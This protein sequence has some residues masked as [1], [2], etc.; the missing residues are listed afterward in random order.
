MRWTHLADN[1]LLRELLTEGGIPDINYGIGKKPGMLAKVGPNGQVPHAKLHTNVSNSKAKKLGLPHTVEEDGSEDVAFI[2]KLEDSGKIVRILKKAHSVQFSDKKGW[3]LIDTDPAKGA[4]GLGAKWIPAD[5]RFTWVKPFRGNLDEVQFGGQD[6]KGNPLS[7]LKEKFPNLSTLMYFIPGLGQ[8]LMVADVASQVQMYNQAMDKIENQYPMQTIQAVQQKVGDAG[9]EWETLEENFADGRNPQ[10]KGDSRRH[11]I[12]K[13]ASLSSLDKITHQGGRKGQLAHWQ[14]NMRRGRMK[15]DID[16]PDLVDILSA[17]LPFCMK[18]LELDQ[19]PKIKLVKRIDAGP[20]PTFG[21]FD[22][23]AS[24]ITLGIS[25]RHP[26]DIVRTLAH[27]LVH[28]RQAVEDRLNDESGT[29]G[30]DEENEANAGAGILMR[31]F[32]KQHPEFFAVKPI[33]LSEE[34]MRIQELVQE[35]ATAG[36]TSAGAIA[37]VPNPHV[38]VGNIKKYGKGAPAKPPKAAQAL[39]K[40]GTAK[41]ALDLP[42]TS[43]MGG[44]LIKR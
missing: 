29:T 33:S 23:D 30:S 17:F 36:G 19:L 31:S 27:E 32:G 5:T 39:N 15:E 16:T 7:Q 34:M 21:M 14:A 6:V 24:T 26:L 3:L 1:M 10:D 43:L 18:S 11:G 35:D 38:A 8:A 44:K 37:T 13:H 4:R 25:N 20:Q 28:Y 40:D 22:P 42:G 12:P 41:N 2:G 9:E